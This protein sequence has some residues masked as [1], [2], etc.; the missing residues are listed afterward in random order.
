MLGY[1]GFSLSFGGKW[2]NSY[3]RE[4]AGD[5]SITNEI[6]Q[7]RKARNNIMK[8]R[9]LI[10][11]IEFHNLD[12]RDVPIPDKS[13]IYCD[14]PYRDTGKYLAVGGFDHDAFW[15]WCDSMTSHGHSVFVSE[16]SAPAGWT[17]IWEKPVK[18]NLSINT[19]SK[20]SIEKLFIKE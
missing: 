8:Q 3:R 4:V 7:N 16:Y 10:R 9:E 6:D 1:A 2:F 15:M 14:P 18:G 11:G 12:Y 19:G 5:K 13:I 20:S 17:S